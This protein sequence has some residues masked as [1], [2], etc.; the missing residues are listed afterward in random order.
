VEALKLVIFTYGFL[1][2]QTDDFKRRMGISDGQ[3]QIMI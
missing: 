3:I 2:T 1:M